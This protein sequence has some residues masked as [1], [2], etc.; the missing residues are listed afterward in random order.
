MDILSRVNYY[1]LSAYML[2]F[3][4]DDTFL[5]DVTLEDIYDT[6]CFDK[7]L[8]NLLVGVL[9]ST[10]IEFRTHI[11]Y[12]IAHKYGALGHLDSNNF[13][14][15]SFHEKYVSMIKS[16]INRNR[17]ELF[18]IHHKTKYN[19]QVPIWVVM[20]ITTF[21]TL[22]MFFNN[23]KVEDKKAIGLMCGV[24]YSMLTGWLKSLSHIRNVCAHYSR[25]YNKKFNIKPVIP[26]IYGGY[27]IDNERIFS[28][29]LVIKHSI[30]NKSEWDSFLINLKALID[31]YETINLSLIGFPI[32]WYD[33]LHFEKDREAGLMTLPLYLFIRFPLNILHFSKSFKKSI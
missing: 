13:I 2:T 1:R 19:G 9:E 32:N 10:E 30:Q 4:A 16:E 25:I 17:E 23:L 15:A 7:K 6:Y 28:F 22:S 24:H 11:A 27:Q 3:K 26:K 8:R 33:I 12:H 18:I 31:Q 21:G 20:E 29:I 5:N 14:K